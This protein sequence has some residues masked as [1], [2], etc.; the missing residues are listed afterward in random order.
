MTAQTIRKHAGGCHCGAVRF[1]VQIDAS[2]GTMCNCS[3]CSKTAWVAGQVKPDAFRLLAG[4][5]SLSSYECMGKVMKR[6]FCKHCSVGCFGTGHLAEL[7]GDFVAINLCALDDFDLSKTEL[8]YWDGRHDNWHA[9][10]RGAPW[11]VA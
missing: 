7:G 2:K 5:D 8:S 1:E 11:P 6:R 9:G 10:T 3:V 4:E